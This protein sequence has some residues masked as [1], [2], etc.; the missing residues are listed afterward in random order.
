VDI[1]RDGAIDLVTAGLDGKIYAY[2]VGK[3][4]E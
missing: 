3:V 2:T 1:N 4:G